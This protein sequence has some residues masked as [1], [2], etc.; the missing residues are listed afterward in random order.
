MARIRKRGDSWQ[1]EVIRKG[2]KPI[3]RTF[4]RKADAEKWSKE[5]E[6]QMLGGRYVDTREAE[7]LTVADAL[8]RYKRE[9]TPGKKGAKREA[10]RIER[11]RADPLAS[12][13]IA[14]LRSSD[15][16]AWRDAKI[17]VGLSPNSVRLELALI[18]HLY[19]I[20]AKEWGLPVVNPCANIRK[21]SAGPGREVRMSPPQ[22]A[23]I[24]AEAAQINPELP[25]W[26]VLAVETGMRRGEVAGLRWEWIKGRV[27]RL[28][29]TKNGSARDVPLSPRA[30]DM[31][32][33][34]PR[35]IDGRV[36]GMDLDWVTKAFGEAAAR[37]GC[38]EI[39]F[40]D[41]RHE[42]TSRF[43]EKG[44]GIMEVAT[45][46]GHKTLAMLRRYTHMSAERLADKLG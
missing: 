43:F 13:S 45:I 11:W 12:K 42:A 5:V 44:L 18:S 26:I 31:L 15:L 38:P 17:K 40:H 19:T 33:A 22:E 6:A 1:A 30:Q 29:D 46:T 10:D 34:L 20:A 3:S 16:A 14:A 39:R 28:P 7:S 4:D 27:V 32:S 9:V 2:F 25:A 41:L 37:A 8:D 36:L 23:A 24:L 35:R 21:P